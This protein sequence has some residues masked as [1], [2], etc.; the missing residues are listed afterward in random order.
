M[1]AIGPRI[2]G[3]KSLRILRSDQHL[4]KSG[5]AKA[6]RAIVMIGAV[7]QS[8]HRLFDIVEATI[9]EDRYIGRVALGDARHLFAFSRSLVM[10]VAL[11]ICS[12]SVLQWMRRMPL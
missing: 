5:F 11:L 8:G 7:I 1:L 2:A 10:V 9:G 3:P 4:G 6:P 12:T